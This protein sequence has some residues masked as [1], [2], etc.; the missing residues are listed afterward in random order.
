MLTAFGVG[1]APISVSSSPRDGGPLQQTIRDVGPVTHALCRSEPG[2]V[3]GVRGPFGT[4]WGV[5]D[6]DRPDG[7]GDVVVVAG[8]IG[9]A[10]LRG[11]VQELVG[12]G[13]TG[14]R[15]VV[16][17][18]GAREPEQVIFGDDLDAWRTAGVQVEVTVDVA[19]ADWDG[20]VGVVTTL[21]AD[22]EFD[23]TGAVALVCGP[24]VMLRFVARALVDRGVHPDRVRVSLE[25]NMQCG[26]AWCGHCQL[27]PILVCRDG[28][29]VSY[30]G[31]V[32]HLLAERER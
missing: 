23:P 24:E 31:V 15:R 3:V 30:A 27:G 1:E 26:I 25:R 21:L 6:G 18:V 29:V 5:E 19:G 2:D 20:Q 7:S 22:A 28:P 32:D 13:S 4:S 10:P 16:V 9:L 8:G 12:G 14:T 17:L 11:I